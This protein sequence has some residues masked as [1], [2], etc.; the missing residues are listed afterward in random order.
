MLLLRNTIQ[1][2]KVVLS[3]IKMLNAE[4]MKCLNDLKLQADSNMKEMKKEVMNRIDVLEEKV[5]EAKKIATEKEESAKVAAAE[6]EKK[7]EDRMRKLHDRLEDLE[8]EI[9]KPKDNSKKD[10]IEAAKQRERTKHFKEQVGLN[11]DNTVIEEE[12]KRRTWSDLVKEN[13]E[14]ESERRSKEKEMKQK[15]WSKKV[16]IV[17]RKDT[18]KIE[19]DKKEEIE[20][21]KKKDEELMI[22]DSSQLHGES[23]WSWDEGQEDWQGTEDRAE[24]EKKKKIQRYRR[25]KQ[26]E[27]KTANK[28]RHMIGLG[29]IR[30]Q[31]VGYFQD[32]NA[33][34]SQAKILAVNEFLMEFLQISEDEMQDFT[35]IDTMI[36]KKED[37]LIYVTFRE[38]SSIRDIHRRAAELQNEDIM[39]HNFIPPQYW[40]RYTHLNKYCGKMKQKDKDIK[41]QIR[42]SETDLEVLIK[43]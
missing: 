41:F 37:E 11:D 28:G 1:A 19:K 7:E 43:N 25:R 9:R 40:E 24:R 2:H 4:I 15:Y 30:R 12:R 31:S 39:V 33:N 6:K 35:I 36:S 3:T 13:K 27:E 38:Y 20:D 18:K 16:S 42:F 17:E 23:D 5:D 26:L 32:T 22:G 10:E 8:K 29:P 21:D 14:E 34:F